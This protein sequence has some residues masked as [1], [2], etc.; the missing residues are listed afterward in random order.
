LWTDVD[1][2]FYLK[3]M[4]RQQNERRVDMMVVIAVVEAFICHA[5]LKQTLPSPDRHATDALRVAQAIPCS[6]RVRDEK[7]ICNQYLNPHFNC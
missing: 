7:S 4:K 1:S 3:K 5:I 2:Q 6:H